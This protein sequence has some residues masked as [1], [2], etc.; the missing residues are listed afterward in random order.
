MGRKIS[1]GIVKMQE[2][3]GGGLGLVLNMAKSTSP[4]LVHNVFPNPSVLPD[5]PAIFASRIP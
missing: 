1:V 2:W 4:K 5:F 3:G